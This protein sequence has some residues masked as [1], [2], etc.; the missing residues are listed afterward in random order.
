MNMTSLL[1][2]FSPILL[3]FS[4]SLADDPDMLQ[5]ICVADLN[6]SNQFTFFIFFFPFSEIIN[7]ASY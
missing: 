3:L 1:F 2:I 7:Y 5:D 4:P 6:S